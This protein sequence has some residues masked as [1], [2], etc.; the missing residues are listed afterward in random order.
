MRAAALT[1]CHGMA[2]SA[3]YRPGPCR[4]LPGELRVA[5]PFD[6]AVSE[7]PNSCSSCRSRKSAKESMRQSGVIRSLGSDTMATRLNRGWMVAGALAA[8]LATGPVLADDPTPAEVEAVKNTGKTMGSVSGMLI[9]TGLGMLGG[10]PA[11]AI[12]GGAAGAMAGAFLMDRLNNKF[13][14]F[15]PG[16]D[17]FPMGSKIGPTDPGVLGERAAR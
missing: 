17:K 5:S 2:S 9:G 4:V 3:A 1:I 7:K 6:Q 15:E 14:I 11:G 12:A 16:R 8:V 13:I 10:G